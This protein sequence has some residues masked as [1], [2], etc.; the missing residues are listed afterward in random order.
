MEPV[1]VAGI[2]MTPFAKRPS[3]SIKQMTQEVVS[4][5]LADAGIER[6]QIEAAFFSNG[7]QSLVEGQVN[8][9]GQI[10]LR[11]AGLQGI[12]VVNV[13]NAC[14][15]GST[16]VWLALQSL[17][18][19]MADV[20]LAIGVEKMNYEDEATNAR[21]MEAF[22][23]GMDVHD[24]DATV[25]RLSAL[26]TPAPEGEAPGRRTAFMDLYSMM[27]RAHMKRFGSTQRQLACIASKNHGHSV[28]NPR[29]QF[30]KP[31]TVEE[32]LAGRPLSFPLTVPMCSGFAD[33][34]AAAILCTQRGAERIG[35]RGPRVKLRAYELV[36]GIERPWEEL[37]RSGGA[38]AAQRAYEAAAVGP[39]DIDLAEVHDA[40]AFGELLVTEQLGFCKIGEGGLLAESGATRL[41]GRIPVNPSGGLESRGHPIG[42]TGLAQIFELTTQLRGQAGARQVEGARLAM[43][44]N[45]GGWLGIEEGAAVA[46]ILERV[47]A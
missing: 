10:A 7:C 34:A 26:G 38:R 8:I 41:G 22:K 1:F 44:E 9:A 6:Q 37:Q 23:G 32:V 40:T 14:A 29:A 18:S 21:V 3:V 2:G 43:Q 5:V 39:G 11:A 19:G 13:E 47:D 20:V 27:C 30:R 24:I 42:A 46:S 25:R 4:E 31:F 45:G 17:R 28:H 36:S 33:G 16:A 12:P 35:L 15:S